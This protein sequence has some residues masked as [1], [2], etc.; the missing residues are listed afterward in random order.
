MEAAWKLPMRPNFPSFFTLCERTATS[1][2]AADS[3]VTTAKSC[4]FLNRGDAD[5]VTASG[6]EGGNHSTARPCTR[7]RSGVNDEYC[8]ILLVLFLLMRCNVGAIASELSGGK[9]PQNWRGKGEKARKQDVSPCGTLSRLRSND[10]GTDLEG[11]LQYVPEE[12]VFCLADP[13]ASRAFWTDLLVEQVKCLQG[14]ERHFDLFDYSRR[15]ILAG[16]NLAMDAVL[17]SRLAYFILSPRIDIPKTEK[18]EVVFDHRPC[19]P[20]CRCRPVPAAI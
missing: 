1:T 2:T 13:R 14:T 3:I 18:D 6:D 17:L 19:S 10:I 9:W 5:V 7:S 11:D 8:F 15:D 12:K 20:R 16:L 4:F